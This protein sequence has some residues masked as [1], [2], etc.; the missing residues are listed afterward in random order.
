MEW[1]IS[2]FSSCTTAKPSLSYD[3]FFEATNIRRT[4]KTFS[5]VA[6]LECRKPGLEEPVAK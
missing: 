4:N 3:D 5:N 2:I 6:F 1:R